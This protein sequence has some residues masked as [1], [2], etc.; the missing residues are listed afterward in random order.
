VTETLLLRLA[1]AGAD[2]IEIGIPFSDPTAEGPVIQAAD[3]RA[4]G[5]GCTTE[6]LFGLVGRVRG[7]IKVPLLFMTYYN[8]VYVYGAVPF[9]QRCREVGIDGLIVPDLPFEERAELLG[10]CQDAGIELISMIAPTSEDR[11]L[12]IAKASSGFL[13]CVSSLGVTGERKTIGNAA[14][15]MIAAAKTVTDTPCAVGFGISDARQAKETARF[16]DGVIVGSA[17]VKIVGQYGAASPAP[18]YRFAKAIK[19]AI[20]QK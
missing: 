4:L 17:L 13:Y 18:V 8:P 11:T 15:E 7:K 3:E 10:P 14:A 9:T 2:I 6:K 20:R 12:S 5:A 1:D 19:D 16:A